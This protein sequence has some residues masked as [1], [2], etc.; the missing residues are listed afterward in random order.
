MSRARLAV[1]ALVLSASTLVGIALHEGYR[2]EAYVPVAGDKTT[3]GFGQTE[4]VK[5]GDKTTPPRALARLLHDANS[6][7]EGIK[8]CIRVP[9]YQHEFDAYSS[10]AYNIGVSAFCGSTLVR[11]LNAGEYASACAEILRWN[12]FRGKP[13]KGLTLRRQAEY[14]TCMGDTP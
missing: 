10:L 4:G 6:H 13:L 8:A 12:K 14:R 7:S 11:R 3:I 2:G 9:L 1:S 5:P